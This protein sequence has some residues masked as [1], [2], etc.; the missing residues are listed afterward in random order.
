MPDSL[1]E[2]R[3]EQGRR[4]F[5]LAAVERD[6]AAAQTPFD[7]FDALPHAPSATIEAHAARA[8]T[9]AEGLIES[10]NP[11]WRVGMTNPS[12][13]TGVRVP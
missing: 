5:V 2:A 4:L 11:I 3:D 13:I 7:A 1:F 6:R 10:L 12:T 9:G 8:E